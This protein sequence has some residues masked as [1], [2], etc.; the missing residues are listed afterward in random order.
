MAKAYR[1]VTSGAVV[2]VRDDKVLD[3]EWSPVDGGSSDRSD[4][5]DPSWTVAELKDHAA[6]NDIDLGGATKKDE[7]LSAI[8]AAGE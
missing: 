8:N 7:I 1:N 6:T 2:S 3:S 5:P 4:T